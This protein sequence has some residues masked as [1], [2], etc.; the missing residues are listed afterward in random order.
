MRHRGSSAFSLVAAAD[1]AE[2]DDP[3][4]PASI[5]A[6]DGEDDDRDRIA[7]AA[8]KKAAQAR[9]RGE[10]D[11]ARDATC[12]RA[13]QRGGVVTS[14]QTSITCRSL[15]APVTVPVKVGLAVL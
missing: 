10:D 4:Q 6:G 2:D 14:F 3:E 12:H 7:D 5:N 1:G 9:Q 15:T 11:R 8:R 13:H